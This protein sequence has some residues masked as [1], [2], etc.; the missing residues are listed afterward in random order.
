LLR[1][2]EYQQTYRCA[3]RFAYTVTSQS[4][5]QAEPPRRFEAILCMPADTYTFLVYRYKALDSRTGLLTYSFEIARLDER[6]NPGQ[7]FPSQEI[8]A[9]ASSG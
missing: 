7:A 1:N 5:F 4:L 6:L 3:R 9:R 2:I 8:Y